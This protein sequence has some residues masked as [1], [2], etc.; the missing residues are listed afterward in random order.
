M[1]NGADPGFCK[2]TT[3]NCTLDDQIENGLDVE[4]SGAVAKGAT[5]D[6]IVT[7]QTNTNDAIFDS[8]QYVVTN[9]NA[10]IINVSYGLCELELG[11]GGNSSYN[12]LWQSAASEGIS[13]LVATGDAGS[14]AC[15]QGVSQSGPYGAAFG[16]AVSGI[17]S[18]PYDTAVG[19]TDLNWGSTVSTY[20]N[21]SN[22][23][24]TGATAKG[25]IP[26]V[27]WNDTCTNPLEVAGINQQLGTSLSASQLCFEIATEVIT[28]SSNEQGA[29]NLVN[30]VGG[31]GGASNCTTNGTTST[32]VIPNPA[33]CTAGYPKPSWQ[34]GVTGITND[35]AR[36]V[37][38][39][40][41]FAG[42]GFLGSAYLIC[43]SDAGTCTSSPTQTAEA[44][45]EE[46]GGTSVAS[47]AMAGIMALINQKAGSAQGNPNAAL[48][49]LAA[50]QTYSSCSA[51]SVTAGSSSCYFNDIDTG[52]IAMACTA[53]SPNCTVA[54][55]GN[56]YGVLTGFG[57]GVGYDE[58]TGLGSLN[59]AN[60]V[61]GFSAT[62]VT[63]TATATVAV[64]ATPSTFTST[65]GTSVTVTVTG[66]SGTP[67][68][69]VSLT[70][71]S[72]SSAT[73]TLASGSATFSLSP[74]L[75]SVGTDTITAHYSGDSVY[76]ATTGTTQVTVTQ[77]GYTLAA[78]TPASVVPGSSAT[79]TITVA[80]T[81]GYV[82]AVTLACS[83]TSSPAGASD[84]PTCAVTGS[85]VTLSATTTSGTATAT[86]TTTA[87][88]T[89][90]MKKPAGGWA[91]AG[92]GAVLALLAFFGIPARRRG[93]RAMMGMLVLLFTIGS[94]AACG[95]GGSSKGTGN[96]GTSA[97]SYTFTVSGTGNP[98]IS[99]API[100]TFTVTVN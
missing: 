95:G 60:V 30:S 57:A 48:Y 88:T 85:P 1:N 63:G 52:T 35:N 38:D 79:S 93:W 37:P 5:V 17:A 65:Q 39:V 32:T 84:L 98:A 18:S 15:D 56:T 50:K 91:E 44:V 64:A 27:P 13:V 42:N 34:A 33:T 86:V 96:P 3:G 6:L 81:N 11:T 51:E 78:T 100:A 12:S 40:S 80:S 14:P 47:P 28:S 31:G 4:W 72:F 74:G 45:G 46:I 82:G 69:T 77:I 19:G 87:A 62:T 59:V 10:S 99:P 68:G 49:A 36:D 97:G 26:E 16:L 83:L 41:F 66:G 29:L 23:T 67:T 54:T 21:T 25:Y 53:G 43:I 92:G 55:S 70:S 20:W 94:L 8:A 7:E 90:A 24:T 2:G 73:K 9:K 61:N 58:A 76:A 75:L 71:G 22:N 89:A